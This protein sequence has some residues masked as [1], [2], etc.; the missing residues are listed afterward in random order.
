MRAYISGKHYTIDTGRADGYCDDPSKD[1]R[2][3]LI[4]NSVRNTQRSLEVLIHE[5]LHASQWSASEAKVERTARDLSR[6]LWRL[7]WRQK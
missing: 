7:K 3:I 1:G 4:P 2:Q 6:I 5:V